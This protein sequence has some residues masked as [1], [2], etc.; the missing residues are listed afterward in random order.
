MHM[1]NILY[2]GI[3][4]HMHCKKKRRKAEE[5]SL[6][7]LCSTVIGHLFAMVLNVANRSYCM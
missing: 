4:N 5:D 2:I 1:Y 7:D 3:A 6:D